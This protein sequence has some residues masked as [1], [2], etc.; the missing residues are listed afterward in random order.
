MRVVCDNAFHDRYFILDKIEV[1]DIKAFVQKAHEK[2]MKDLLGDNAESG[3][4][5]PFV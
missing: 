3:G 2:K 4:A 5:N 1:Y